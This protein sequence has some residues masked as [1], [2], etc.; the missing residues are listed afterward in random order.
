MFAHAGLRRAACKLHTD[1]S[2]SLGSP[3]MDR[4]E[5]DLSEGAA[6]RAAGHALPPVR[7]PP[8][9]QLP[10]GLHLRQTGRHEAAAGRARTGNV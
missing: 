4:G 6:V 2:G 8:D 7:R 10:E 9:H 1:I 5:V 3:D